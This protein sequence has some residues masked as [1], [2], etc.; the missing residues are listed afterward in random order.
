MEKLFLEDL[1]LLR[2]D[3]FIDSPSPLRGLFS[4]RAIIC[5]PASSEV[6]LRSVFDAI[7]HYLGRDPSPP[8]LRPAVKL[9][10]DVVVL[11]PALSPSVVGAVRPLLSSGKRP[12]AEAL[13]VLVSAAQSGGEGSSI[14]RSV[15][16]ED[17]ILSL[18]SSRAVAVRSQLLRLLAL[19]AHHVREMSSA[20]GRLVAVLRVFLGLTA[21]LHPSVRSAAL[22]GL[23]VFCKNAVA[24]MEVSV[25]QRCY[26]VGVELLHDV[27][28]FVK[29]SAI[30][31]VLLHL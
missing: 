4:C 3:A 30:R 5:N 23:L 29:M 22:E 2:Q 21:D 6:A 15:M 11:H 19:E 16:R 9:L 13:A 27:D 25:M 14:V 24:W 17:I 10:A 31:L 28:V 26:D 18:A 7:V 20:D 12:A 8:L 1:R